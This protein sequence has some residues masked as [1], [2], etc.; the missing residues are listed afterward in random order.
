MTFEGLETDTW[1]TLPGA[2]RLTVTQREAIESDKPLLCVVAGAG[3][4]KTQGAHAAGGPAGARRLHRARPHPGHHVQP[5]GGGRV[6]HPS[7]LAGGVRRE[8]RHLPPHGARPVARAPRAAR[9]SPPRAPA[10]PAAPAG[11]GDDRR[12]PPDPRPRRRD[13]LGQGEP[14]LARA[15]RG[16]GAPAPAAQR[17]QR[18]AGGGRLHPLRGGADPPAPPRLRRPHRVLRRRA[19][20]RQ[21]V[22]RLHPLAHPPPVRRR[23]AGRQPGPVPLV[24]RHAGRRARPLRGGRP[25]PV[26]LRVQRGR[27]DPARP[28]AGDPPRHGRHPVG[29]EPPLH[30]P[31]GRGGHRRAA[32]RR[33]RSGRGARSFCPARHG[34]TGP[35]PRSS[36]TPPPRTRRPGWPTGSKCRARR[37]GSGP[38]SPC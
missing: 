13:R 8:G 19:G 34:S 14:G 17:H 10:G 24:D 22:R 4:G 31:G 5:Q 27:P 32:G 3:A 16:R 7:L 26:G 35:S 30:A 23:D 18:R 25:Q 21:R 29:R 1:D 9:P 2:N 33:R 11:R 37:V 28:A 38:A 15:V 6:A 36:R 20:G 12:C